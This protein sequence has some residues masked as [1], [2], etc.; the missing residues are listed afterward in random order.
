MDGRR[1][2][3]KDRRGIERSQVN[4]PQALFNPNI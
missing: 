2:E 3:K 4:T 1:G